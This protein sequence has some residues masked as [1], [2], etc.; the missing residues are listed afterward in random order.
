MDVLVYSAF[1]QQVAL[2]KEIAEKDECLHK[3]GGSSGS[4]NYN[5]DCVKLWLDCTRGQ[6][7]NAPACEEL[8][9][10]I[11][12]AGNADS[13]WSD[14][15]KVCCTGN[16]AQTTQ[17]QCGC[18]CT[19]TVP[20]GVTC[21]KFQMWGAGSGSG[22]GQYCGGSSYGSTGA[23]AMVRIPVKAGC[24]YT[25][26]AGCAYCCMP[27]TNS[28]GR[29]QG[30]P[31]YVDGYGLLRVCAEGGVGSKVNWQG[32]V[33][34]FNM[35]KQTSACCGDSGSCICNQGTNY[36]FDNSCAICQG[37]IDYTPGSGYCGC[38]THPDAYT[39]LENVAN[40][41]IVYG[42]PGIWPKICYDTNHYG[43]QQHAPIFCFADETKC[44]YSWSSGT[45]CGRQCQGCCGY[46]QVPGAGGWASNVMGGNNG[47]CGDMG[48]G[49][50]VCVSYK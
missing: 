33:G 29:V 47:L 5:I 13:F 25:L 37:P 6:I 16:T 42:I 3:I 26:C 44:C 20:A 8:W 30:C 50:M 24:S 35:Y 36:C 23:Y 22:G 15:F 14:G 32:N 38:V 18:S 21:A 1:N 45:C 12:E 43:W 9:A 27:S 19:W 49:G 10:H 48:K 7:L 28:Q 17:W 34:S 40:M 46:M 2:R 31:S 39:S 41:G 11:V 4:S